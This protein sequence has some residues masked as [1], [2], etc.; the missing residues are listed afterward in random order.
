MKGTQGEHRWFS[1]TSCP[2][3]HSPGFAPSGTRTEYASSCTRFQTLRCLSGSGQAG[4][5]SPASS[6]QTQAPI[7]KLF[8]WSASRGRQGRGKRVCAQ[9]AFTPG[10]R[11]GSLEVPQ[12]NTGVLGHLWL[13]VVTQRACPTQDCWRKAG[14]L[15]EGGGFC[16][17]QWPSSQLLQMEAVNPSVM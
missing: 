17:P 4:Y 12:D 15:P 6:T 3:T 16:L 9:L 8:Q 1:W 11:R 5:T 14:E 2:C 10:L 13:S 7:S